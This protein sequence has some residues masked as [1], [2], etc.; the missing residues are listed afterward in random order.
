MKR[1]S[2]QFYPA[3][4]RGNAKLRRCQRYLRD[5][6]L[7]ILCFMHDSDEYGVLRWELEEIAN[8][9]GCS[10]FDVQLLVD[11]KIMKG[12]GKDT[13][14][15]EYKETFT[16]KDRTKKEVVL[17]PSQPG[18]IWYSSRFVRDEYLRQQR[19]KFG[20]LSQ[21]HPNVPKAKGVDKDTMPQDE[22]DT[23]EGS[24]S[25]SSTSSPSPSDKNN[26]NELFLGTPAEKM[27]QFIEIVLFRDEKDQRSPQLKSFAKLISQKLGLTEEVVQGEFDKFIEHWTEE[28]RDGKSQLWKKQK[29]FEVQKRLSKWFRNGL[30]WGTIK[31]SK[32]SKSSSI[33]SV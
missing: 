25:S 14:L 22:E 1:P 8:A 2:F 6:W 27:E 30:E 9:V 18:P 26:S 16:Q 31:S 10:T 11:Y 32:N 13:M 5:I 33:P 28:T 23:F 12:C 19:G 21:N 24:P 15:Q 7:D 20:S 4:W 17:L 29:T 3:D